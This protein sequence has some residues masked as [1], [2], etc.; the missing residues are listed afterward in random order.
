MI[1]FFQ[2]KTIYMQADTQKLGHCI[3]LK[4]LL[5]VLGICDE[6]GLTYTS[7]GFFNFP[8]FSDDDEMKQNN[9]QNY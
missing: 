6:I 5:I 7:I 1:E 4:S 8:L 9:A 2:K 3:A